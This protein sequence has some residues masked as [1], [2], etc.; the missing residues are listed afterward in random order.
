MKKKARLVQA[1]ILRMGN[2]GCANQRNPSRML[3]ELCPIAVQVHRA[4]VSFSE[5][6]QTCGCIFSSFLV[7]AL[8]GEAV[9]GSAKR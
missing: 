4:F 2:V 8:Y 5:V 7:D 6:W 1:R 9:N 3:H